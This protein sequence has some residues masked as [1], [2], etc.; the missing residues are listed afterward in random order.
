VPEPPPQATW[1][2]MLLHPRRGAFDQF[3]RRNFCWCSRKWQLSKHALKPW[4]RI[5]DKDGQVK[6]DLQLTETAFNAYREGVTTLRIAYDPFDDQNW[7]LPV[8]ALGEATNRLSALA[9]MILLGLSLVAMGTI[10]TADVFHCGPHL[11]GFPE[12]CDTCLDWSDISDTE[13]QK[14]WRGGCD[15]VG[16]KSHLYWC[17]NGVSGGHSCYIGWSMVPIPIAVS[18]SAF[19]IVIFLQKMC[20]GSLP[21]KQYQRMVAARM[22][23]AKYRKFKMRTYVN[24]LQK[25]FK[26]C[27]TM[28][29][30][31]AS[32]TFPPPPKAL[33]ETSAKFEA[34]F[35]RWRGYMAIRRVPVEVSAKGRPSTEYPQDRD[36]LRRKLAAWD[37]VGGGAPGGGRLGWGMNR[38]WWVAAP[39]VCSDSAQVRRLPESGGDGRRLRLHGAGPAGQGPR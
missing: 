24:T 16:G 10:M 12:C 9:I 19:A 18:A 35:R 33:K 26:N 23:W 13:P 34:M 3:V 29:D 28:K 4:Q 1:K 7:V 2:G 22:I 31:G 6:V 15:G 38:R 27:R 37:L 36:M 39:G 21:R 32:L 5:M 11:W 14:C 25:T 17:S 30:Y 8:A 20:R